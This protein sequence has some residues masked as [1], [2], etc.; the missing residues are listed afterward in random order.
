MDSQAAIRLTGTSYAV[1][2]LVRNLG[3]ATPYDLKRAIEY[4]IENFWPVPHTTFYAEPERLARAG[5]LV[6]HRER[7]GRRR[8]VYEITERGRRAL[9]E[10]ICAEELSPPQLRDEATL[11]VF[12]GGN[13]VRIYQARLEWHRLKLAELDGYLEQVRAAARGELEIEMGGDPEAI[14]GMEA[15]L[16]AGTTYHRMHIE[17]LERCVAQPGA[18]ASSLPTISSA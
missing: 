1:L 13:P 2:G 18:M 9:A 8:K 15:S 10:W 11:K 5:Y 7:T 4:S 16:V 14:A 3:Q 6:E 12:F 17:A